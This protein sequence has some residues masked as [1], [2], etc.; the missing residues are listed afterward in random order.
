MAEPR[1]TKTSQG[2]VRAFNKE[3]AGEERR[4]EKDRKSR[5]KLVDND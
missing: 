1:E 3:G 5:L 2:E 4:A